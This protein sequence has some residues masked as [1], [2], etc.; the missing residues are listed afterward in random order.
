M[1]EWNFK[2]P[3]HKLPEVPRSHSWLPR[4]LWYSNGILWLVQCHN[5]DQRW[6][7]RYLN[8]EI[9]GLYSSANTGQFLW[10]LFIC[11]EGYEG[12]RE[13][14]GGCPSLPPPPGPP[15]TS[16]PMLGNCAEICCLIDVS[17]L[18]FNGKFNILVQI[19][20]IQANSLAIHLHRGL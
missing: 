9:K 1:N 6:L 17:L 2:V 12:V 18:N 3:G 16:P 20:Q 19:V 5:N 14:G 11:I 15:H 4:E 10:G 7:V 8:K 13:G